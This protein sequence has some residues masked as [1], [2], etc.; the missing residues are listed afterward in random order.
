MW[1]PAVTLRQNKTK[2]LAVVLILRPLGGELMIFVFI[3]SSFVG[4]VQDH[5]SVNCEG[6]QCHICNEIINAGMLN[7][8]GKCFKVAPYC[9]SIKLY[10]G[11]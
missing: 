2:S 4:M 6:R 9:F 8:Y 1:N 7:I 11:C 3:C 5:A 10:C